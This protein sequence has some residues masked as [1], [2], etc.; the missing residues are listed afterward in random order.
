MNNLYLQDGCQANENIK[1]FF[2]IPTL[3]NII[4]GL[5]ADRLNSDFIIMALLS[6]YFML[7][8]ITAYIVNIIFLL[9]RSKISINMNPSHG[10][11]KM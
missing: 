8:V 10:G 7:T 6:G 3:L 11:N 1:L 4:H 9:A 5:D 2:E